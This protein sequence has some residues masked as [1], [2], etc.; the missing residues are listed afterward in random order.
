MKTKTATLE[1]PPE[2]EIEVTTKA[3]YYASLTPSDKVFSQEQSRNYY[4]GSQSAAQ[5]IK[6]AGLALIAVKNRL[7]GRFM[8]FC[9]FELPGVSH[10]TVENFMRV[11]KMVEGNPSMAKYN[12]SFLFE[13][14][15]K[16]TPSE[17]VQE[18]QAIAASSDETPNISVRE[19]KEK[20]KEV[21]AANDLN[22]VNPKLSNSRPKGYIKKGDLV[23][24]QFA[25]KG[26]DYGRVV[27]KSSYGIVCKIQSLNGESL[28]EKPTKSL[29]L[30]PV[31][32][33]NSNCVG[34]NVELNQKVIVRPYTTELQPFNGSEGKVIFR[35]EKRRQFSIQFGEMVKDFHWEEVEL[36]PEATEAIVEVQAVEITEVE[37]NEIKA[38]S[39]IDLKTMSMKQKGQLLRE[40]VKEMQSFN[41]GLIPRVDSKEIDDL[42]E[43]T[44]ARMDSL[45][46][47]QRSR[48][49]FIVVFLDKCV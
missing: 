18:M 33:I 32:K 39:N 12:P 5:G 36:I 1:K 13:L 9:K 3:E 42:V 24:L 49:Q 16:S 45:E 43:K 7:N 20:I 6:E 34:E 17:V 46:F 30:C 29:N 2:T 14:S 38:P 25:V 22:A 15:R 28:G 31:Q 44:L 21:K 10:D 4:R 11:A 27:S 40:L 35:D 41:F 47:S 8:D 19:L 37:P 26:W 23:E 48:E